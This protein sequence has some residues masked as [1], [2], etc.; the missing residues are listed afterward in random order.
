MGIPSWDTM[1][2]A[3]LHIGIG[4]QIS[5]ALQH[6]YSIKHFKDDWFVSQTFLRRLAKVPQPPQPQPQ[7]QPIHL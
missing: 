6:C 2:K 3:E 7:P 1:G 4:M 5:T